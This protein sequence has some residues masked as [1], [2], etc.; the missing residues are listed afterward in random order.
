MGNGGWL[1]P[2]EVRPGH[3]LHLGPAPPALKGFPLE[4]ASPWGQDL[5]S[6]SGIRI[7]SQVLG[8]LVRSFCSAQLGAHS[9]RC[10][11]CRGAGRVSSAGL[12]VTGLMLA[13][14]TQAQEER[15]ARAGL[16]CA[17]VAMPSRAEGL[18]PLSGDRGLPTE[19]GWEV[20]GDT[21]FLPPLETKTEPASDAWKQN[22]VR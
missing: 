4:A 15:G 13:E 2:R 10:R 5:K 3:G 16:A 22:R 14:D 8:W 9:P 12:W 17:G 21:V 20:M 1:G 7:L 11:R 6:E 19:H 18:R